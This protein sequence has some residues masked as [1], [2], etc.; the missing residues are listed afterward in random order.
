MSKKDREQGPHYIP[1]LDPEH[2]NWRPGVSGWI[3]WA[4]WLA[5]IALLGG[6]GLAWYQGEMVIALI[7]GAV[8]IAIFVIF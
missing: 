1:E 6:A 5:A 8:A 4:T 7:L 3:L 2:P